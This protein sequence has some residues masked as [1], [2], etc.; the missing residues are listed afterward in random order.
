MRKI[1]IVDDS[2]TIRHFLHRLLSA[3]GFTIIEAA[4]GIEGLGKVRDTPDAAVVLCDLNMPGMDGL[5]V[6]HAVRA[7][8]KIPVVLMTTDADPHRILSA[9]ASG[10]QGWLVKPLQAASVVALARRFAAA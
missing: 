1:I 8:S 6:L 5:Q 10:A 3:A 4:D 2:A 7:L 9:K